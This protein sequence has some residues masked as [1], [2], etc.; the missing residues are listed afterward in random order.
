M[1]SKQAVAETWRNLTA[2]GA[3]PLAITD[4]LNFANP[5]RPEIMGQLVGAIEGMGEACRVLDYPVVSGNVSLYNETNGVGIPPTPA[6]GAVGL[7][8]DIARMADLRL[9]REGDLVIVIGREAGHLGQSLYQE[10]VDRQARGRAAARRPRRRDQGRAPRARADPRGQGRGRARRLRRRADRRRRRDGARRLTSAWSS[11]PT[12][13]GCP[14]TPC[15]SARTKAA[16]S[17]SVDPMRAEEVLERARLL[18]LPG[19][20]IGRTGG[21]AIT[22]KGEPALALADLKAVHEGWLPGYMADD[23][24]SRLVLDGYFVA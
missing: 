21:D 2:V 16:T 17:L 22:V 8:P 5:E 12:R 10:H 15:G 1:G 14:R 7:I 9:K 23:R 11:S 13:A 19:R 6:I 18:A 20:I 3:D 4:N 24:C